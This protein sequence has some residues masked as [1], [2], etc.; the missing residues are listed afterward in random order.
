MNKRKP[1]GYWEDINNVI[2]EL[3]PL[4]KKFGRFP[5][6]TE[7]AQESMSSLSRYIHKYHG[8]VI[9]L[10]KKIGVQTYDEK[11]GRR[12]QNSWTRDTVIKE[13]KDYIRAKN[14]HYYPSRYELNEN[15]SDIYTGITQVFKN[16]KAFKEVL[17]SKSYKLN[18]KPKKS[19]WSF[20]TAV[21]ELNPIINELGYFPSAFDL[22]NL[23]LSGLRGY[24]SKNNLTRELKNHFN[25]KGKPRKY[26]VSRESGYWNNQK[27]IQTE[28]QYI[29]DTYGRIPSNKELMELGYGSF[30]S[31]IKK[32]P[33][34]LLEKFN[35][36]TSSN[37]I[38]T[39]DGDYV[40]SIYELIFDNFLSYNK[41]EH[42]SE[43]Q[44]SESEKKNYLYDFKLILTNNKCVYV[45]IWGYTRNRNKFEKAYHKKRLLKEQF[46][47]KLSLNL[48]GIDSLIF[49]KPFQLIYNHFE[50]QI[51]KHDKS[52]KAKKIDLDYLLYGSN[53]SEKD[54]IR[55]LQLIA[56]NNNGFFPSTDDL[57]QIENG[58]GLISQ[59]QKY[60]GVSHFKR[61]LNIDIDQKKS[62]WSIEYL[63]NELYKINQLKYLP[64]YSE[65]SELKRLDILGGIHKNGG[66]KKVALNLD[67]P[68]KSEYIKIN[69]KPS[70]T[71]WTMTYLLKELEPIIEAYKTVPSE[72]KLISFGRGDIVVGIKQNGGF[73]KIKESL[74]LKSSRKKWTEE[75]VLEEL[76]ILI[77]KTQSFPTS[78]GF[79]EMNRG[80]LLAGINSLGGLN[81]FRKKL[82]FGVSR[83]GRKT[84]TYSLD[85]VVRQLSEVIDEIGYFP[86]T[87]DL[88]K[89]NKGYLSSRIQTVGGFQKLRRTM[90]YELRKK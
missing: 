11:A 7:M 90:G 85:E 5:S 71:K 76:K 28:L 77:N 32:L 13:F 75:K 2:H 16:Y 55:Q 33:K 20:E 52:F 30:H 74:N 54:V 58:E 3:E 79:R 6:N 23:N 49:E 53:Y 81:L 68:S 41:I 51:V 31:H 56:K 35:Y 84:K 1:R 4:I 12:H 66:F 78:K 24:I 43:G 50:K 19:K 40:R 82:G 25:V 70:K 29:Y 37:L 48:I 65:L 89:I 59:I 46:Y 26:T 57:R 22:D 8:G 27:N 18:K 38:K 73:V 67:I 63:K 10:A 17:A 80:D 9:T 42:S 36:Y 88:D 64:S 21:S 34:K 83:Q 45:E 44:I 61:I 72:G 15:G 86:S 62:K 47:K 69:P 14:I 60:G 87:N 39:K